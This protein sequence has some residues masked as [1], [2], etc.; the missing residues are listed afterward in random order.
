MLGT[1][2]GELMHRVASRRG[3]DLAYVFPTRRMTWAEIDEMTNRVAS[4]LA[5]RGVSKGSRVASLLHDGPV[6]VALTFALAKLG[7]VRVGVNY[8][9]SP[10]EVAALLAHSR[11]ELIVV[12][13]GLGSL[14]PDDSTTPMLD[15][16]D[17]ATE[18]GELGALLQDASAD[19]P[20]VEVSEL[21]LA[22]ICYTTGST[23]DPKGAMWS[24]RNIVHAMTHTAFDAGMHH[25]EVWLHCLPGAG[26]PGLLGIWNAVLG[27]TIV[28]V[29][30]FEPEAVLDAIE[31]ESVTS[32][33]WVPT[34]LGAV[35]G[36][37]DARPRDV[38]SLRK[39]VY[40]SAPTT[41]AMIRRAMETFPGVELEQWYGSTEG[42]GGWYTRLSPNDHAAAL[43]G[44]EDLLKSAGRP[45]HHVDL[46]VRSEGRPL[47]AGETG[48]VWVRGTFTMQGYLDA[49]ELS[50]E[51]LDGGWLCTG[52][53]G[54]VD[55]HGYLYLVDRK[56]F[57]IITGGYNVYPVEVENVI[58]EH[59]A[60]ADVCVFGVPDDRWG[61]AVKALVVLRD[62][63]EITKEELLEF[64]RPR[65]SKFKV[66]KSIEIR[67][68]LP[69]GPTGKILKRALKAEY[70]T[71][72]GSST[73]S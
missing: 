2:L 14:I 60:V 12:E 73:P 30:V 1:T 62:P 35:M 40:G 69:K 25:D 70:W 27:W 18:L 63:K 32:T 51:T 44:R 24:H 65:L 23:G 16:G 66:P 20:L 22:S 56:Q 39:I 52:D 21:D 3:G 38:G 53:L 13:S 49:P 34:M 41:P 36:A 72:V 55:D 15:A 57:L 6:H 61:E 43:E 29:P 11:A 59:P 7:A 31:A 4:V 19:P 54:Y 33:V 42:A 28:T 50:G 58:A 64:C 8:R 17:G 26:V 47:P 48:D 71:S 45:M 37:Q 9:Y 67:Q 46:Q 68:E 5:L 10:S